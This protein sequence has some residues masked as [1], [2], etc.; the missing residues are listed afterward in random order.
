VRPVLPA[1]P[2][3]SAVSAE[4]TDES[5][6]RP[7]PPAPTSVPP[8]TRRRSSTAPSAGSMPSG[9]GPRGTAKPG[10]SPARPLTASTNSSPDPTAP[11]PSGSRTCATCSSPRAGPGQSSATGPTPRASACSPSSPGNTTAQPR[12]PRHRR[13]RVLRRLP[14]RPPRR[15]RRAARTRRVRHQARRFAGGVIDEV[16]DQRH[17]QALARYARWHVVARA[18]P[19]CHGLL[20]PAVTDR[21]RHEIR[22]AQRFFDHLEARGRTIDDCTQADLDAWLANR[23]G[24]QIRFPRWLLDNGH[25]AGLVL[26]DAVPAAGPR[27]QVDQDEHWAL[28]RRMLHD[29]A[30]VSTED[31][32]AACSCSS[33]H[34]PS[35]RL[36]PSRPTTS[37]SPRTV[38]TCGSARSHYCCCHGRTR[39]LAAD[40]EALRCGQHP[41]R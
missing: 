36:S 34:N 17:Q 16:A 38:P 23:R 24:I 6:S 26:P 19:D 10:A 14:T 31:G 1:A 39:H 11:S 32:A 21:C 4:G 27:G 20:S 40:R 12:T 2:P 29:E 30:G 18:R 5:R 13:R 22:A 3:A 35:A 37:P 25:L 28:V 33:T 8:A 15:H 41:G 9:D 7:P